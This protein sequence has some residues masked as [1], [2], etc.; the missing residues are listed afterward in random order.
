VFDEQRPLY[1]VGHVNEEANLVGLSGVAGQRLATS[2]ALKSSSCIKGR[3]IYQTARH[4]ATPRF[5]SIACTGASPRKLVLNAAFKTRKRM[6][7]SVQLVGCVV[8]GKLI[9]FR[10]KQSCRSTE[11]FLK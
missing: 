4:T 7:S 11:E 10:P 5:D 1:E 2:R 6:K 9:L 3:K 8:I